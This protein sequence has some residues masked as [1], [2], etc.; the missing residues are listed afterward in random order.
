MLKKS[1]SYALATAAL[2]AV[3]IALSPMTAPSVFAQ[4]APAQ[5]KKSPL[6]LEAEAAYKLANEKKYP[7]AIAAFKALKN[8]KWKDWLESNDMISSIDYQI[9]A[10]LIAQKNWTA[11]EAELKNFIEKYPKD[12]QLT[13]VRL[14][15]VNCY[16]QQERWEDA[17]VTVDAILKWLERNPNPG[18]AIKAMLARVDLLQ[19]EGAAKDKAGTKP[20]DGV[21]S[22]EKLALA[23][24]AQNLY[25]LTNNNINSAEMIEARQKLIN[26]YRKLGRIGEANALKAKVDAYISGKGGALDP[27]SL[28]RSNMQNLEVG[29]DYFG[30]A[31]DIDVEM[32]SDEEFARRQELFR[33]ALQIY[34]GVMRKDALMKCFGPALEMSKAAVETAKKQGGETPDEKAQ[35]KIDKAEEELA[36]IEEYK[37]DLTKTR[38]STR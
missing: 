27:A 9:A 4:A 29:D 35:A 20:P 33:Q 28:I 1:R 11:A 21:D 36:Q 5:P 31:Q 34:Q 2:A 13:D 19:R 25:N 32:A 14:S 24:S 30:Q 22:W 8:G 12:P 7:E 18:L 17:R 26:I 23:T 38:T 10:C 6:E 3:F 37:P 16:I 15:L